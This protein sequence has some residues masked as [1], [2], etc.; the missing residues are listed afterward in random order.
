[1]LGFPPGSSA[2]S[3]SALF[4]LLLFA[5]FVTY[6]LA[7]LLGLTD[8]PSVVVAAVV[9]VLVTVAWFRMGRPGDD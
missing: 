9:A 7:R 4:G 2:G 5:G 6:G 8:Q 1:M 3:Q